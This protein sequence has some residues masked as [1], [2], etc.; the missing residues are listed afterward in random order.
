MG[1]QK[2]YMPLAQRQSLDRK[3]LFK[4]FQLPPCLQKQK[5]KQNSRRKKKR[6]KVRHGNAPFWIELPRLIFKGPQL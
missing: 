6:G 1:R 2:D 4:E 3:I 5:R